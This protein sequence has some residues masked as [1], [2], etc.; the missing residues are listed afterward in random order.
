MWLSFGFEIVFDAKRAKSY[1]VSIC[2]IVFCND[3]SI[4][5]YNQANDICEKNHTTVV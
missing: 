3:A 5:D 1:N 4:L 2:V